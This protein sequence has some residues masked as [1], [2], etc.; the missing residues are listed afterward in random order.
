[1]VA[2]EGTRQRPFP[3]VW[4]VNA[5]NATSTFVFTFEVA[6]FIQTAPLYFGQIIKRHISK[7]CDA[8][9]L[10]LASQL[11]IELV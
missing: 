7:P 5:K 8:F 10:Q 2:V 3:E 4:K 6:L 9:T 1:M 11:H